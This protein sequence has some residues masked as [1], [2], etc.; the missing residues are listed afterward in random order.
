MLARPVCCWARLE[1]GCLGSLRTSPDSSS[2][3]CTCSPGPCPGGKAQ[4]ADPSPSRRALLG[5]SL[6][7]LPARNPALAGAAPGGC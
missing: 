2:P 7:P 5:G 6:V 1:L 3:L 4:P